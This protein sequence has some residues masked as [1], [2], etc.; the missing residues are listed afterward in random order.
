M[1][2]TLTNNFPETFLSLD[3]KFIYN[4]YNED[5]TLVSDDLLLNVQKDFYRCIQ[6]KIDTKSIYDNR[7]F[8]YIQSIELKDLESFSNKNLTKETRLLFN[9]THLLDKNFI[10]M[11]LNTNKAK[12]KKVNEYYRINDV[13][14]ESIKSHLLSS[15]KVSFNKKFKE[16]FVKISS[17]AENFDLNKNIDFYNSNLD[18]EQD[19]KP[20]ENQILK[21]NNDFKIFKRKSV[22]NSVFKSKSYYLNVGFLIEKYVKENDNYNFMSSY[23]RHNYA[24]NK[25]KEMNFSSNECIIRENIDVKDIAVKYGQTYKYVIYPVFLTTLP[26]RYDYHTMDEY[27][28]CG[29]PHITNDVVCK[30]NVRP[31]PPAQISFNFLEKE[32]ALKISWNKPLELQGDVKGY[33]I[34]KRHSLEDPYVLI[35]QL[36][37]HSEND[38]YERNERISSSTIEKM[39]KENNTFYKDHNFK[40]SKI[41]IYTICSIDAHGFI[42]NYSTQYAVK[43]NSF[44]KKCEIDIVSNTGA[45]IHMPNLL[46]PRKT[47]FF[48]NADYIVNNT[49]IEEKVKKFTLYV[50][51]EYN[52][53]SNMTANYKSVLSDNYKLSIFKL[54]NANVYNDSIQIVNFNDE[55]FI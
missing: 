28:F 50:T 33:Q 12:I 53:I 35:K 43:Y 18:K 6:I 5:E 29:F 4:F 27:I 23:Y 39:S 11:N 48:E 21:L 34:F 16:K 55:N 19:I 24:N 15:K 36:E 26:S 47:K 14:H 46:V 22:Y 38:F 31:I 25:I 52:K 3:T 7:V 32:E 9:N 41:Q 42:S 10:N 40:K 20:I 44:L 17:S 49:P 8:K 30:E 2:E 37:F 13:R 54:E 1:A 45:P 51:P